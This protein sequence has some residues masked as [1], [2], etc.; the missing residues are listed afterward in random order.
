MKR[1]LSTIIEPPD[2]SRPSKARTDSNS[3]EEK[4][5]NGFFLKHQNKALARELYGFKR[6]IKEQEEQLE[7]LTESQRMYNSTVSCINRAWTQLESDLN[8]SLAASMNTSA[9]QEAEENL[10]DDRCS[11]L[12]RLLKSGSDYSIVDI[13]YHPA[14]NGVVKE[15]DDSREA[16][17]SKALKRVDEELQKRCNFTLTVLKQVLLSLQDK[18]PVESLETFHGD[19]MASKRKLK[20]KCLTL[21]DQLTQAHCHCQKLEEELQ[22]VRADR[23]RAYRKLDQFRVED[24][25]VEELLSSLQEHDVNSKETGPSLG[26][27]RTPSVSVS[28]MEIEQLKSEKDDFQIL[29]ECRLKQLQEAYEQKVELEGR[30]TEL[31]AQISSQTTSS[32]KDTDAVLELRLEKMSEQLLLEQELSARERSRRGELERSVAEMIVELR[33]LE[34][35]MEQ[36]ATRDRKRWEAR[37]QESAMALQAAQMDSDTLRFRV[38]QCLESARRSNSYKA[39]VE[40]Y[41]SLYRSMQT[42]VERL[43]TE[44][45]RSKKSLDRERAESRRKFKDKD[46]DDLKRL[47]AGEKERRIHHLQEELRRLKIEL[48]DSK[49]MNEG[50]ITEVES[51]STTFEDLTGQ[52]LRL[53]TQIGEKEDANAKLMSEHIKL[54]QQLS[55]PARE[56][57][58]RAEQRA[59]VA[60][61]T[62]RLQEALVLKALERERF[63][64]QKILAI[65]EEKKQILEEAQ[66][67]TLAAQRAKDVNIEFEKRFMKSQEQMG[68]I[69]ARCQELASA[70]SASELVKA[71]AEEQVAIAQRKVEKSL[72]KLGKLQSQ[73]PCSKPAEDYI[74]QEEIKELKKM[75]QCSVCHDR[76]KNVVISKCF[77]MFCKEC[78]QE[79]LKVRSRKC[80]ACGRPFGQD[81]VH[82]IWM[83]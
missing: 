59:R 13:T 79:N 82:N 24:T 67:A 32:E 19:L 2:T 74:L 45:I 18:S 52:S 47:S 22:V 48:D 71:Q 53:L 40:E 64:E 8:M 30:I 60:E 14:L 4:E 34:E 44:L 58:S 39:Q 31:S 51:L 61:Q 10:S 78:V 50:L 38:E 36:E 76:R 23:H 7:R 17:Q 66:N 1:S 16:A 73:Q 33:S 27:V 35:L 65:E 63:L 29:A 5:P 55:G 26:L 56:E 62:Q 42:Q 28:A 49:T 81:D 77:H 37:L 41:K 6:R 72:Q 46:L 15:K 75:L 43:K 21:K 80:P 9:A 83:T 20:A 54:S 68:T 57:Q 70:A 3:D 11:L 25:P 69:R 12:N